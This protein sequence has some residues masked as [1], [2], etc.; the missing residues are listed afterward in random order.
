MSSFPRGRARRRRRTRDQA[1][2]FDSMRQPADTESISK[3]GAHEFF[4]SGR[5]G[6]PKI[7]V[8]ESLPRWIRL[9]AAPVR[10]R[11]HG[12]GDRPSRRSHGRTDNRLKSICRCLKEVD[13]V[14]VAVGV[15]V[16]AEVEPARVLSDE[17]AKIRR[18]VPGAAETQA[19]FTVG[20]AAPLPH[21][22]KGRARRISVRAAPRGVG[23]AAQPR[24]VLV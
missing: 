22:S 5:P 18:I 15:D 10:P 19:G 11:N 24:S 16:G 20:I 7:R 17:P 21:P 12:P 9:N 1:F 3:F 6:S 4:G 8:S 23:A 2:S 13:R 14:V